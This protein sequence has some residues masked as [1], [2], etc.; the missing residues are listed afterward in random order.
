MDGFYMQTLSTQIEIMCELN[1]KS[2]THSDKPTENYDLNMQ[3][4]SALS[5]V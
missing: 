3:L 1:V 5:L 4:L 2:V